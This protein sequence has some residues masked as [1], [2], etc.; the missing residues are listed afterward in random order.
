MSEKRLRIKKKY[1]IDEIRNMSR[2]ELMSVY[3]SGPSKPQRKGPLFSRLVGYLATEEDLQF[4]VCA[5]PTFLVANKPY[6]V[7][8]QPLRTRLE[9]GEEDVFD[10]VAALIEEKVEKGYLTALYDLRLEPIDSDR[11]GVCVR[12]ALIPI[13]EDDRY[14]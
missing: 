1:S 12:Y 6:V 9:E 11:T 3:H 7:K 10:E 14:K 8:A 13:E 4:L 5:Y 2:A